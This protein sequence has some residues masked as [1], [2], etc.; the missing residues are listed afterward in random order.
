MQ[1]VDG[2]KY[3]GKEV[4][5]STFSS[6]VHDQ[7]PT[8]FGERKMLAYVLLIYILFLDLQCSKCNDDNPNL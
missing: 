6:M 8:W 2:T 1:I 5:S 7:D 3:A 4:E